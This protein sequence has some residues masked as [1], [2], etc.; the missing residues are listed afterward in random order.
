[1]NKA[2][3]ASSCLV[4]SCIRYGS[5][6]CVYLTLKNC[7]LNVLKPLFVTR[8]CCFSQH[9]GASLLCCLCR[10]RQ[11][12]AS[13]PETEQ[14][15]SSKVELVA[16]VLKICY[17]WLRSAYVRSVRLEPATLHAVARSEGFCHV[18]IFNVSKGSRQVASGMSSAASIGSGNWC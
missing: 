2:I 1:M 18:K 13:I 16:D 4:C 12:L 8:A 10:I 15:T 6:E 3:H 5:T 9:R 11:E 17:M 7:R 14:E